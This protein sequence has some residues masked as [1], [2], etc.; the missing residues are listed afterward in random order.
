[1]DGKSLVISGPDDKA[2]EISDAYTEWCS[3]WPPG[4]LLIYFLSDPP[5]E[6]V[7]VDVNG[8]WKLCTASG[9]PR[10]LNSTF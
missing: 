8:S 9:C 4:S 1:M 7:W 6:F 10:P 3:K 2:R 5:P